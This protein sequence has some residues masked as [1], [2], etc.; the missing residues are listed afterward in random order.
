MLSGAV[1]TQVTQGVD[2]LDVRV[3]LSALE[4]RTILDLERLPLCTPGGACCPCRASPESN[5]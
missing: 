5:T 3:W 2:T 1:P 4:R